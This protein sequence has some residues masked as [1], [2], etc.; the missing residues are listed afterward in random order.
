MRSVILIALFVISITVN[1]AAQFNLKIGYE[2]AYVNSPQNRYLT[3][4]FNTINAA[5]LSQ[6]KD[7]PN[8]GLTNGLILGV[9]YKWEFTRLSVN[10]HSNASRLKAFGET[11][12]TEEGFEEVIRYNLRGVGVQYEVLLGPVNV[13]V[14]LGRDNFRLTTLIEGTSN[15][16]VIMNEPVT[17][18]RFNVS[19][20]L[21]KTERVLVV[22]EPYF[23][24][25]LDAV[26]H[27]RVYPYLGVSGDN[28]L[29]FKDRPH[30]FGVQ[31][32][33]YNGNQD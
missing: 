7:L 3:E 22:V 5:T 27:T 6:G 28:T 21:L 17:N 25:L 9:S 1:G 8:L 29:G 13:G 4:Q 23:T 33:F 2:A 15:D 30:Y 26:D 19:V 18:L 11:V 31:L 14:G 16:K 12:D 32:L 10:W 20:N 24:F